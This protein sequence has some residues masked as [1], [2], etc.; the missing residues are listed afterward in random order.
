MVCY[1]AVC[2]V[3]SEALARIEANFVAEGVLFALE[4]KAGAGSMFVVKER[5]FVDG[6]LRVVWS[7]ECPVFEGWS[8]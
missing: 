4:G 8:C 6:W 2:D 1:G 3:V 5:W 7:K